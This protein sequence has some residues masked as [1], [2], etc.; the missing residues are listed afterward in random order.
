MCIALKSPI[1]DS[2]KND[3]D[4]HVQGIYKY[5]VIF[6]VKHYTFEL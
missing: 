3:Q 4:I 5:C 6:Q 1:Y 2:K